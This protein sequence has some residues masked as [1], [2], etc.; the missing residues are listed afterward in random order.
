M[1]RCESELSLVRVERVPSRG[2]LFRGAAGVGVPNAVAAVPFRLVR[3]FS[4]IS[5]YVLL[6]I[7]IY[8]KRKK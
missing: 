4:L 5:A 6:L 3:L 1:G 8:Y 2:V 7:L